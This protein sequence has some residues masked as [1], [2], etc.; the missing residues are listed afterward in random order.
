MAHTSHRDEFGLESVEQFVEHAPIP[1]QRLA[2]DGTVLQ[3]N[4]ALL[5][6]LGYERDRYI[7]QPF[8][9]FHTD[10]AVVVNMLAAL[11]NHET[12]SD[13]PARLRCQDGSV[14]EVLI[15]S[16]AYWKEDQLIHTHCFIRDITE[17]RGASD[18]RHAAEARYQDLYGL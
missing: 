15:T 18:A 4:Q 14:R 16:N 8:G 5:Y 2:P 1:I 12:V 6:L 7:G 13:M 11:T 9:D 17:Q 10:P 3:A